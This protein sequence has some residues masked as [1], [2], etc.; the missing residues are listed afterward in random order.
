[1]PFVYFV[2]KTS[3]PHPVQATKNTK[4]TKSKQAPFCVFCVFSW[5]KQPPF[6]Y[7]PP[8]NH[9]P[10]F[11]TFVVKK[12][13]HNPHQSQESQESQAGWIARIGIR[14]FGKH[15]FALPHGGNTSPQPPHPLHKQ[16]RECGAGSS[17]SYNLHGRWV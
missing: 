1:M 10:P 3:N 5:P 17:P 13:S 9:H 7:Q 15:D 4:T 12:T 2:V 6:S 11:R 14:T 8:P 16:S